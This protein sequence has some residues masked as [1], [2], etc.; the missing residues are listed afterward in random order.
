MILI[1][2]TDKAASVGGARLRLHCCTD[3]SGWSNAE[4]PEPDQLVILRE[5]TKVVGGVLGANN[6]GQTSGVR[7]TEQ[8]AHTYTHTAEQTQGTV[9][10]PERTGPS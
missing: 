3:S 7:G 5:R 8:H 10:G 6:N 4:L 1:E 2:V 9:S